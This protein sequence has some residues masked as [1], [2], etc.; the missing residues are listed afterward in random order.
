MKTNMKLKL[1][2][3][4]GG[5]SLVDLYTPRETGN[6]KFNVKVRKSDLRLIDKLAEASGRSRSFIL[7]DLVKNILVENLWAMHENDEDSAALFARYVDQKCGKAWDAVDGWT[8]QMFGLESYFAKSYWL[9]HETDDSY[10]PGAK[11]TEM[12]RRIEALNK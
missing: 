2:T 4:G 3:F 5:R 9:K 8:A 11:Y 1:N 10:D 7:N 6:T 12:Q